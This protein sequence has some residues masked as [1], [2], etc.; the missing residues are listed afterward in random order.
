MAQI[1]EIVVFTAAAKD[2]A[3]F[4]LD[5]IEKRAETLY[6]SGP[7]IKHRLYR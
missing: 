6:G 3:D 2:Y 5:V 4:I 1:F 7:V